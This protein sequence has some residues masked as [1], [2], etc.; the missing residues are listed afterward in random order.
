MR[1]RALAGIT[2]ATQAI[3][4]AATPVPVTN[5]RDLL[6]P[7]ATTD[8]VSVDPSPV[9]LVG[10]FNAHDYA[11][12]LKAVGTSPG[13]LETTMSLYGF[14]RG[15]GLEWE[16]RGTHDLLV[17]RVFEFRDSGG[18]NSWYSDLKSGSE[19]ASHYSGAIATPTIPHSFGAVLRGT[20]TDRQYRVEFAKGNLMFVVHMDSDTNDLSTPAVAQAAAEYASAPS[21]SD[22]PPGAGQAVNDLV[23]NVEIAA[24]ALLVALALVVAVTLLLATRRRPQPMAPAAGVA[25]SPDGAY[26]WDGGRWRDASIEVPPTATRSADGAF[27]W[28]GRAWRPVPAG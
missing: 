23:R 13:S 12:F 6:T 4:L 17:E 20:G 27:W 9:N 26:W 5:L 14:T 28:D 22:V 3:L 1:L 19:T 21:Q 10:Y 25:M 2:V 11:N 18:A 7:P 8:W 16:Q 15:Y 24:G